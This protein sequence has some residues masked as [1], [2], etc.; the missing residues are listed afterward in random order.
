MPWLHL[1]SL[2]FTWLDLRLLRLPD[3]PGFNRFQVAPTSSLSHLS[4]GSMLARIH[5]HHGRDATAHWQP[6]SAS[7]RH[8]ISFW[9]L[10]QELLREIP[11]CN[12]AGHVLQQESSEWE[13]GGICLIYAAYQTITAQPC[14]PWRDQA[15]D[16]QPG[17]LCNASAESSHGKKLLAAMLRYKI[18]GQNWLDRRIVHFKL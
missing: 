14:L 8:W 12:V 2:G 6:G 7:S 13:L 1:A 17:A 9:N 18:D 15:E 4:V 3:L 16:A 11:A 10:D 5:D